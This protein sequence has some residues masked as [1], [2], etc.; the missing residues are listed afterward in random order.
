[1]VHIFF[2]D[3]YSWKYLDNDLE[4]KWR[5]GCWRGWERFLCAC[6]GKE[7]NYVLF[8]IYDCLR[9]R[10]TTENKKEII[11]KIALNP[12]LI[13]LSHIQL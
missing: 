4:L 3:Y 6:E 1:M 11:S 5:K 13:K 9:A 10:L 8:L 2:Y 12:A 7:M